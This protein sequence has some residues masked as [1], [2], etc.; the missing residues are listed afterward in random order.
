MKIYHNPRCSTSRKALKLITDS[1]IVPEII[2]YQKN[3][4]SPNELGTLLRKMKMAPIDLIRKKED[5][6]KKEYKSKELSDEEWIQ[7]MIEHPKLMERPIVEDE[8]KA[9]LG[10]PLEKI[11]DLLSK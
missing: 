3:A 11:E 4:L 10:R 9:V 1:G 5:L 2:L 8:S 6:F 7:I